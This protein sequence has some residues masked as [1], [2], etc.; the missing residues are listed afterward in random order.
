MN[1]LPRSAN[2]IVSLAIGI[3]L[4]GTVGAAAKSNTGLRAE[5]VQESKD[6]YDYHIVNGCGNQDWLDRYG[7]VGNAQVN[8]IVEAAEQLHDNIEYCD[9]L[10]ERRAPEAGVRGPAA[11][12]LLGDDDD[13]GDSS[14][15]H[16]FLAPMSLSGS[17]SDAGSGVGGGAG[18]GG[19]NGGGGAG[20]NVDGTFNSSMGG[21]AM[22]T[23]GDSGTIY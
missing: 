16:A 6:A 22:S 11:T 12:T 17:S 15:T 18:G 21:A 7:S 13:S 23:G 14:T 20:G 9:K 5:C 10:P 4:I 8:C 2:R 3:L 1:A 19:G